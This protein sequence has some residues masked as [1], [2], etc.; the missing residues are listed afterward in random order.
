MSL[1][2]QLVGALDAAYQEFLEA[3][4]SLGEH[5]FEEKWLDRRWGVREISALARFKTR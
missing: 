2:D 5:E 4:S 1:R 3:I